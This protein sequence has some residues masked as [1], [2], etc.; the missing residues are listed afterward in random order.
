M[1]ILTAICLLTWVFGVAFDSN[2]LYWISIGSGSIQAIRTAGGAILRHRLDIN[3]LMLV[4]GAGAVVIGR[5]FDAAT[6]FM[7]FSLSATLEEYAL[8]RTER[9]IE[10]LIK[11]RPMT[12]KRVEGGHES[13]VPVEQIR[14]GDHVQVDSFSQIPVDGTVITGATSVDESIMTGEPVPVSKEPGDGV[15]SATQNLEGVIVVRVTAASTESS[16]D[17]VISLV[18]EARQNKGGYERVSVWFGQTYTILVLAAFAAS[19]LVRYLLDPSKPDEAFF[20]SLILLVALSPCALVIG[21]PAAILSAL[22]SSSRLGILV[23]GGAALEA[24]AKTKVV[25][26]DKTGTLTLGKFRVKRVVTGSE[27]WECDRTCPNS[28]RFALA[29]A[30]ALEH[31]STHPLAEAIILCAQDQGVPPLRVQNVKAIPGLGIQGVVNGEDASIGRNKLFDSPFSHD[32]SS[33]IEDMKAEGLTVVLLRC[34]DTEVAFGLEDRLRPHAAQL[35]T[36]LSAVGIDK[37]VML[38]GDHSGSANAVASRVGVTDV[39]A[40]LMPGQK[41]EHIDSLQREH[42]AVLMLGDG[43]NDAPS[44]AAATMG[45]AMGGLGSDVAINAADAVLVQDR[46]D[47]VPLL[48]ALS[49]KTGTIVRQNIIFSLAS[50]VV[51]AMLSFAGSLPL[52]LAVVVHEGTTLLVILNGIRLL[53]GVKLPRILV[54]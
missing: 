37:V 12:A 36:E 30:A 27:I 45:V 23:R 35:V 10:E 48:V 38:T 43:I 24:A 5:H 3:I 13:I 22:A 54:S 50:I 6:L 42:G 31:G 52:S 34:G 28:F 15:L 33:K 53:R 47:R 49:K 14:V 39:R 8:G 41:K 20:V 21:T 51:L 19:W 16:I 26:M 11:L 44:L 18:H 7:L 9:G 17:R 1:A 2:S 40:E 4:A 46:L 29:V 25:A 32:L